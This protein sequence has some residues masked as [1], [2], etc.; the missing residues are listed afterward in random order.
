MKR[1]VLGILAVVCMA[2]VGSLAAQGVT[3]GVGGGLLMPMGDYNTEDKP[4]FI[5]GA[6]VRIPIGTAPVAVR[7]EGTYS[8]TSHDSAATGS[9]GFAGKTKMI[10]GMASLVYAIPTSG[11]VTPYVLGGVGVY[12]VKV[13]ATVSGATGDTSATKIGFGGGAGLRFAMG[14]ASLFAEARYMTNKAFGATFSYI[15]IIVGVSFG[16][17]AKQQ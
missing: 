11:S 13:T 8:Q 15:P 6:G 14:S 17:G 16:G 4:G 3:F 1:M 10:G 9:S 2:G 5:A 7:I 12:N